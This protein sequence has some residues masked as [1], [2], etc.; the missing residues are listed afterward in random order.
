[1]TAITITFLGA[2][3]S[4]NFDQDDANMIASTCHAPSALVKAQNGTAIFYRDPKIPVEAVICVA[5]ALEDRIGIKR[6]S[7]VANNTKSSEGHYAQT[8]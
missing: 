4:H 8:H 7:Y 1:M 6:I 5:R 2:C 3:A